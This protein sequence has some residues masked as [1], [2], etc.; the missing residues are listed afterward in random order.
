[1]VSVDP[2]KSTGMTK[3]TNFNGPTLE[4]DLNRYNSYFTTVAFCVSLF[5]LQ[6]FTA[7]SS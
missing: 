2:L 5:R 1:M 3:F 7:H 4:Y 6:D